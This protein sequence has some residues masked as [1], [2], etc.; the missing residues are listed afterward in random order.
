MAKVIKFQR[1]EPSKFG[2]KRVKGRKKVNLEEF[3]QLNMFVAGPPAGKVVN[4]KPRL[5]PFE[6]ALSLDEQG[7]DMVKEAYLKAIQLADSVADAYCN[8]GILEFQGGDV[9]KAIDCL[10]HSLKQDP[11]HFQSHYNL[12][13]IYSEEGNLA[14][15]RLHYEVCLEVAPDFPHVYYNLGLV[16]A[17]VKDYP[18]AIKVL[19]KFTQLAPE[20]DWG[21]A[22]ELLEGLKVSMLTPNL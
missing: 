19:T 5:S 7:D 3:G 14:L 6:T 22:Q 16:L 1:A 12:G 11:R 2:L 10:S 21:N 8:L 20:E 15:A 17:L 13:N 9:I 18:E 4:L